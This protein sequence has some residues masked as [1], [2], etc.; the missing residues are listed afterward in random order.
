MAG[1]KVKQVEIDENR[2]GQRI[3][4]YLLNYFSK[5]PKSRVY[6]A[7]RSGEVRVNKCRVKPV[8][9]L[10]AGDV[11][12]IPPLVVYTE[13]SPV[14]IPKDTITL[15]ESQILFEDEHLLA[16]DKPAGIAAHAGSGDPY[17]VIEIFRASR[18]QQPFLELAHRID[19]ETSGCLLLAKS[20]RVLLDIQQSLQSDQTIKRYT[21]FV[22]GH[23][24][25]K[26]YCV[27]HALQKNQHTPNPVKVEVAEDG[28][29]AK[30][31]FSTIEIIASGSLME[32]QIHSGRTHQIR[33]H[34]QQENHP[35][36][37]DRRY[38]DFA[39]NRE[40]QKVGL[41]R[42][43]LHAAYLK[44]HLTQL[45]QR[46]EFRAPLAEELEQLCKRLKNQPHN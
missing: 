39:Y 32:A 6:R 41:R 43:F 7:L 42:M 21:C 44:I 20:R 46:Y 11:V 8:Y 17:G 13:E 10:Q 25:V 38:G 40:L 3:D 35:I 12:R 9:R 37:G 5:V 36:A 23:W 2:A 29:H 26:N 4:N 15:L 30:T 24:R 27:E 1:T 31:I 18:T 14:A 28:L 34:A 22:K 19:K 33:V 16:L 45:S